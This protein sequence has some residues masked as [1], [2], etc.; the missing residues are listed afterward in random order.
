MGV[1]HPPFIHLIHLTSL[2]PSQQAQ[3]THIQTNKQ[4]QI[5]TT[6]IHK[7]TTQSNPAQSSSQPAGPFLTP[8]DPLPQNFH[9]MSGIAPSVY[10]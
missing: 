7:P 2:V 6:P 5:P 10:Y 3:Q 9:V 4:T 8:P 1:S